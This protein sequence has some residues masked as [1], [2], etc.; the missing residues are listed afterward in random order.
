M[1]S[2]KRTILYYA[3]AIISAALISSAVTILLIRNGQKDSVI[4][5]VDEYSQIRDAVALQEIADVIDAQYYGDKPSREELINQAARGMVA[6][7]GDP[8]SEYFTEE[9]YNAYISNMNGQYSGIGILLSQPNETGAVVMD[10]YEGNPAAE[11][12]IATG[13][14]ITHVG[15]KSVV[16]M[17]MDELTNEIWGED[18]TELELSVLRDA[19]QLT[20]TVTRGPVNVKRVDSRLFNEKTGYI[21]ID[22]FTGNC[23]TEFEEALRDLTDRGMRSL[24]IDLRNNPGGS[25][26]AVVSIADMVLQ[27][28]TI[29]SIRHGDDDQGSVYTSDAK[30]VNVP[31]AVLVNGN[32]ASASEILA[33]AVQDLEAGVVVGMPTFGKGIVQTSLRINANQAWLKLT[34]DAYY[35]PNGSNIHGIGIMPDIEVDLD[36]EFD[37]VPIS[38]I[39]QDEDAQLWAAL[40][41]IREQA[42]AKDA[43]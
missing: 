40:D 43:A 29:V 25:L 32:S 14:V 24:L 2:L 15:G 41:Y 23:V 31:I 3:A 16:G 30:G 5:T 19:E 33:G 10:V 38:Q 37:N 20:F 22:M 12:G 21:R 13:D 42:N 1:K 28:G 36:P 8:Y 39:P 27:S 7:L 9:E 26:D 11:A 4:L 18:G 6:S 34:T 35:T 17:T